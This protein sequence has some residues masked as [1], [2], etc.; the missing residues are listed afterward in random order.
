MRHRFLAR[1]LIK[2]ILCR[3]KHSEFDEDL[4]FIPVAEKFEINFEN[5]YLCLWIQKHDALTSRTH[6]VSILSY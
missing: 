4:I 1:N 2:M 5:G 3:Y 6:K